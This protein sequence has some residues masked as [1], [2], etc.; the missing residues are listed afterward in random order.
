MPTQKKNRPKGAANT[1]LPKG[2]AIEE[3]LRDYFADEGFFS[4]RSVPYQGDGETITDI[5]VFLYERSMS[6]SRRRIIVD[7]KNKK[8]PKAAERIVWVKGLQEVLGVDGAMIATTDNRVSIQRLAR[9]VGVDLIHIGAFKDHIHTQDSSDIYISQSEFESMVRETDKSRG[10]THWVE[11]IQSIKSIL[12][13]G[14]GFRSANLAL[15]AFKFFSTEVLS[16]PHNSLRLQC[17]VR[18]AYFAAACAAASLDFAMVPFALKTAEEKL[19]AAA[20]G[21]RYG[22]SDSQIALTR[23][24]TAGTL[25]KEFLENGDSAAKLIESRF[26]E[27]AEKV[28]AEVI[29]QHISKSDASEVL[30]DPA[31]CLLDESLSRELSRYEDLILPSKSLISVFLDFSE[32]SRERFANQVAACCMADTTQERLL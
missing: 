18:A 32:I 2:F 19:H 14:F 17:G 28:Q 6:V 23:V 27:N 8:T 10:E 15:N 30:F 22:S 3:S 21:I 12:I 1:Q 9:S 13:S 31:R 16:A 5:D 24:R 25:V 4:L 29:A 11:I 26:L 7:V 20:N